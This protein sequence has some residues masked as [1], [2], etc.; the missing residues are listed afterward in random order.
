MVNN[1][2]NFKE[3]PKESLFALFTLEDFVF[4]QTGATSKDSAGSNHGKYVVPMHSDLPGEGGNITCAG[5]SFP[6]L[7]SF[8]DSGIGVVL[9]DGTES[10][11]PITD[12]MKAESDKNGYVRRQKIKDGNIMYKPLYVLSVRKNVYV[13][14]INI[15]YF[16]C[17]SR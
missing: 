11:G 10:R 12:A 14:G 13:Y 5:V 8:I 1:L 3:L 17:Q 4:A 9:I 16:F 2:R 15:R 6:Q 7:R